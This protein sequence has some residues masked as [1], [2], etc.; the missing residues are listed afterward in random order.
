MTI[1]ALFQ[2]KKP[3]ISFEVFPPKKDSPID[4]IYSTLAELKDLRPDFISVT[5]GAGGSSKDKTIEIASLIKNTYDIEALAHFTCVSLTKEQLKDFINRLKENNISNILAL[6]GDY[7]QTSGVDFTPVTDFKYSNDLITALR[8]EGGLSIGGACYPEGHPE[9]VCFDTDI[10]NLKRK[11][12]A[13]VDFL[14]TQLF[15]DNEFFY[16][17]KEKLMKNDINTPISTGIMPVINKKQIERMVSLCGSTL[18]PKFLR[19]MD[20]YEHNPE[21]LREAGIAYATEQIIDLLSWGTEGVHIYTMNKPETC[22]RIVDNI[23]NIRG[24][25]KEKLEQTG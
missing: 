8:E 20:R 24:V 12:E 25:L 16:R 7:P 15:F 6:R 4:S 2:T 5:Y 9:A 14:I 3:V 18:P 19:I 17:F 10:Q 21:A 1:K 22:K 11:V 23:S 13:G